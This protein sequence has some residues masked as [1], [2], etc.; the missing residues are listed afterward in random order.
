MTI[1]LPDGL[2]AEVRDHL[3]DS[4]VSGICQAA[5]RAEV[6]RA[7][8][9]AAAVAEGGF[10]RVEVYDGHQDRTMAFQGREIGYQE[11]HEVTAYL[12]Q[13]GA[14]AVHDGHDERLYVYDGWDD[15]LAD[16]DGSEL[17]PQ[18]AGALGEEYVEEL[19]I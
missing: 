9:H 14:I 6:D 8:A 13:K 2:A 4:N 17:A 11:H 1:Y 15:F 3:G 5:L 19:D 16:N 7:K 10:E 18:V 12:T